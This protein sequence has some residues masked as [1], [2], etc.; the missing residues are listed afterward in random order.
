MKPEDYTQAVAFLVQLLR[1]VRDNKMSANE[2][3]QHWD[4][5]RGVYAKDT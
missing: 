3:I 4:V 2:A 1:E 5:Y